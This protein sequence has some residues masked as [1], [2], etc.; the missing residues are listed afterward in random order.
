MAWLQLQLP[1]PRQ[2]GTQAIAPRDGREL[3]L[4]P[5]AAVGLD[6]PRTGGRCTAEATACILLLL[7]GEGTAGRR[8]E[9]ASEQ[10]LGELH[11]LVLYI[12]SH[13]GLARVPSEARRSNF[14]QPIFVIMSGLSWLFHT[15]N[16]RPLGPAAHAYLRLIQP[17][18]FF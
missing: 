7:A 13:L 4:Q 14:A 5:R 9:L 10:S 16:L 1:Q 17:F 8:C 11:C 3:E 6:H 18:L 12:C 2:A 15:T